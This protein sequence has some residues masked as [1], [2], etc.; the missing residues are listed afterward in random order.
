MVMVTTVQ[1]KRCSKCGETKPLEAFGKNKHTKDGL[2]WYCRACRG[3]LG[4]AWYRA[5]REK[6]RERQHRSHRRH[7]EKRHATARK[8]YENNRDKLRIRARERRQGDINVR[9]RWNLRSRLASAIRRGYKAGSAVRDLGCLIIELKAYLAAMFSTGMSWD[10]YGTWEIDHIR[11]L[12]SF[13][14]ANSE[15]VKEACHYTNLQ[16]LWAKDNARKGA[17]LVE[18]A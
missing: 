12:A 18:V 1:S 3:V 2:Q 4:R 10:N 17:R 14:L 5:N 7:I 6:S 9:L 13:D 16:P 11:P 15:Q 8:Y